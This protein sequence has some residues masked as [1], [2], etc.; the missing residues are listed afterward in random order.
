MARKPN[1]QFER[2]ERARQKAAKKAERAQAKRERAEARKQ[3]DED[4]E[5]ETGDTPDA[6]T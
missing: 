3:G 6:E 1:Y 2:H 5:S 4:A